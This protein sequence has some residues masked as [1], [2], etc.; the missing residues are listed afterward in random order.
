MLDR[1]RFIRPVRRY[2][3]GRHDRLT[4]DGATYRVG[5][6]KNGNHVLQLLVGDVIQE[7]FVVKS[8][9]AIGDLLRAT[10]LVIEEGYFSKSLAV[11]R[12]AQDTSDVIDV[13]EVDLRTMLWKREWCERFKSAQ[14]DLDAPWRPNLTP[15]SLDAFVD[16]IKEEMD[17]WYRK[18]FGERRRLGRKFGKRP[19]KPFDYPSASALRGWIRLYRL[20]GLAGFKPG[21]GNCGNRNQLDERAVPFIEKAVRHYAGIN[22]F[23]MQDIVDLVEGDLEEWN[24]RNPT[25]APIRVSASAIRRRIHRIDPLMKTLGRYGRAKA[26]A[27]FAPVGKGLTV[28]KPLQRVE[29]DDWEMDLFVLA[30]KT[31]AWKAMSPKQRKSVPRIRCTATVAIDVATRCIVGFS[32]S[33]N[34]P[35]TPG[36]KTAW[37]SVMIDKE[38][39]RQWAQATSDWP[40]FG[41]PEFIV[42]DGGPAFRGDFDTAVMLSRIAR[43][44]PD[45]DPRMR[46]TVESFF[47]TFKAICRK[48]AGRTFS[49]VVEKGDY[50]AEAM[51]SVTVE[52]IY[53]ASIRYIVDIY[54]HSGHR[55]LEGG[56]PYAAWERLANEHSFAPQLSAIDLLRAFGNRADYTIDKHGITIGRYSYV[57]ADLGKLHQYVGEAPVTTIQ[58]PNDLGEILVV[59][60]KH[61]IGRTGLPSGGYLIA[62]SADPRA[63]GRTFDEVYKQWTKTRALTRKEQIDGKV[64]RIGGNRALFEDGHRTRVEAGIVEFQA[65]DEDHRAMMREIEM[66]RRA[67]T[68]QIEYATEPRTIDEGVGRKIAKPARTGHRPVPAREASVPPTSSTVDRPTPAPAATGRRPK[69]FGGS[70]NMGG[71]DA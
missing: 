4:I 56:T 41:R 25:Q 37:R 3:F 64:H 13:P 16:A 11:L 70:I 8:D 60:P 58:D 69:P 53:K 71:D 40:M 33:A 52:E 12:A 24:G 22:R 7:H 19:Q 34:A 1:P 35:S 44:V 32:L 20:N 55:G 14:R 6:S 62:T 49:N 21:Y 48:F 47:K 10:R 65:T 61:L 9:E 63:K 59:I 17:D 67:G 50:P 43:I 27:Q 46:G 28:Y 23:L 31:S 2:R 66:K 30:S 36:S 26:H 42:T 68:G 15:V 5:Q 57:S 54:H 18:R 29:M 38:F 39:L 51:A 45:Q